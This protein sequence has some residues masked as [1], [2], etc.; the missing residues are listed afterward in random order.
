MTLAEGG[1]DQ[2]N[3][4][5]PMSGA[6]ILLPCC[7]LQ[8]GP[9]VLHPHT[10]QTPGPV[11]VVAANQPGH[12]LILG[13]G[14]VDREWCQRHQDIPP[15]GGTLQYIAILSMVIQPM[16]P[17]GGGGGIYSTSWHH[18]CIH[19]QAS[20]TRGVSDARRVSNSTP[21]VAV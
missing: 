9:E 11:P 4:L 13:Y 12:L 1:L 7:C 21:V 10:G 15:R 16:V 3:D 18:S 2:P 6:G 17:L 20:F 14:V 19:I 8:T 5:P